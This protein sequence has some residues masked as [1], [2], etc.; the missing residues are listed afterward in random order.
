MEVKS[1]EKYIRISPKKARLVADMVRGQNAKK[2]LVMLKFVP[3]KAANIIYK[4]LKSAV[5]NAEN[6]FHL[7]GDLLVITKI[8]IDGGPTL[9]R[10]RPRSKGMASHILKRTS[11]ITVVVSDNGASKVNKNKKAQEVKPQEVKEEKKEGAEE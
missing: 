4:A 11:H 7:D 10:F 9:K 2:S 3:K 5:A 1:V 6:N 8:S